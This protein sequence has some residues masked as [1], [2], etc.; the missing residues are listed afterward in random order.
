VRGIW[1]RS[2]GGA[3]SLDLLHHRAPTGLPSCAQDPS[4]CSGSVE[5]ESSLEVH[6]RHAGDG[7]SVCVCVCVCVYVWVISAKRFLVHDACV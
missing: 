6:Q 2:Q 3:V 1:T 4:W 7:V 5:K